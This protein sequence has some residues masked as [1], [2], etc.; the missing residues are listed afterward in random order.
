MSTP[1][2]HFREGQTVLGCLFALGLLSDCS[3][4]GSGA[5][6]ECDTADARNS[7]VK[8]VSDDSNNALVNYAARNSSTVTEMAKNTTTEA[9]KSAIL[10]KAR[11]GAA[12]KLDETIR[13]NSR[14]KTKRSVTC[15]GLLYA[16]VADA[17][18]EKEV[19]FKVEQTA[20]GKMSVSVTPFQF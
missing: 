19:D 16:T 3:G 20:D 1:M 14:N 5:G 10:E 8:I 7:V 17:T 13:M 9:E 11:K 6:P 15:S 18:A 4:S 2:K 12:Y